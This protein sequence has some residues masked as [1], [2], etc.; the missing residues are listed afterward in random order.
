MAAPKIETDPRV[1]Q[2]NAFAR[3]VVDWMRRAAAV[4]NAGADSDDKHAQTLETLAAPAV[5]HAHR[6]TDQAM[7]GSAF[8][9]V[10]LDVEAFDTAGAY[11][12]STGAFTAPAAGFYAF[13]AAVS[14]FC[15]SG[16]FE[17][18]Q[19]HFYRNGAS[20]KRPAFSL[21]NNQQAC[22]LAGGTGPVQ[23]SAGDVIDL[24]VYFSGTSITA[25]IVAGGPSI[26]YFSGRFVRA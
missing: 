16:T 4:V 7:T 5:F 1:S 6:T 13:D 15:T 25:P 20:F 21:A 17:N 26:S 9:Q 12:T 3:T 23:L 10:L 18:V 11:S 19:L 2:G 24:R 22:T 8:N 14:L